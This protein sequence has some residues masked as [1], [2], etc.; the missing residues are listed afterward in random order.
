[1]YN[2]A[3]PVSDHE[4]RQLD[5]LG[6]VVLKDWMK[7]EL[8][9]E[10]RAALDAVF[11]AE[12]EQAGAEFRKEQ[13]TQR[14]AN[15]VDKGEIFRRVVSFPEILEYVGAVIPGRFKLSSLNARSPNP[16]TDWVQPLHC[17]TGQLADDTGNA[18]CNVIWMVDDFTEENGATRIVPG[19]HQWRQLPQDVLADPMAAHPD[20]ILLTGKAGTVAIV[21][22]HAWHGGTAN[23]SGAPRRCLHSFYCRWDKP[24]QQFQRNL[25]RE[26]TTAALSPELRQLLAIDDEE[27]ARISLAQ[28][29]RSGFLK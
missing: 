29:L 14:L 12:G 25:L 27:N 24:Q 5:E 19:S 21:N 7:P 4:R 1:M 17:D 3:M 20:E 15:L 18:I 10:I 16:H 8:L 9:Q 26:E 28:P 23:R 2:H 6:F 13:D 11:A 22:T